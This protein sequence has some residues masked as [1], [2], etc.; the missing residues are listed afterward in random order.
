[1]DDKEKTEILYWGFFDEGNGCYH[2]DFDNTKFINHSENANITQ[3]MAYKDMYLIAKRDIKAGEELTQN[4]LEF[5][6]EQELL[7]R[8]IK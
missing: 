8:G 7:N 3:D 4:Y 5:E 2:V 1:M 6:S